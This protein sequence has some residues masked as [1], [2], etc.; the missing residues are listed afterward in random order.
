M[1]KRTHL[2]AGLAFTLLFLPHVNNK[3]IF[4]FITLLGSLIPDIDSPT[5]YLGNY[6]IFRPLQGISG[7]RGAFHSLTFCIF[8]SLIFAFFLPILALSFFLGY[9]SHIFADSFT[10]EGV[11]PFWPSKKV[12]AGFIR[13]G[14]KRES[15]IFWI[16]IVVNVILFARLFI[17]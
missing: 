5:S 15:F 14:G 12:S 6:K 13:T 17:K 8:F 11:M 2:A 7:H 16:L 3:V 1:M 10:I 4:F 9:S